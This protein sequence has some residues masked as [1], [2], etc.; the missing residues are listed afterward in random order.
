M[1]GWTP[2]ALMIVVAL[3][4]CLAFTTPAPA[5]E[6]AD[7][8]ERFIS[9]DGRVIDFY[10]DQSSHS[11]GQ[12]YGMLLAWGNDE[13][14]L[15][16]RLWTWT[17]NNLQVRKTD[18]LLAW[19]WGRRPNGQWAV[20]DY[21]NASDGDLIAAWALLLAADRW[22]RE[23]YREDGRRLAAALAD[24]LVVERGGRVYLMPG[25]H[26][27]VHGDRLDLNPSYLVFPA[28]T[29]LS[30]EWGSPWDRVRSDAL[31][32]LE[33]SL[34]SPLK[35]PADWVRLTDGR[36][37]MDPDRG[38]RFGYEAIRVPLYLAWDDQL[39]AL[40]RFGAVLDLI[41]RLGYAP[42]F[43]DLADG[44]LALRPGGAGIHAVYARAAREARRPELARR[45]FQQAR[46]RLKAEADNYYSQALYLLAGLE[47]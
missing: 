38:G 31:K 3:A 33:A 21:N 7:F 47:P 30:E 6:W 10:Q 16:D 43:I 25:Y 9:A 42:E 34:F 14:K 8:K 13:P 46:T 1:T 19:H 36:I 24:H 27:F 2:K 18:D 44:G 35:I 11:E 37:R 26:G 45:L 28:L 5:D 32:L 20:L 17:Q 23:D 12:A 41:D 22:K 29:R 40:P 15:F 39:S 4:A